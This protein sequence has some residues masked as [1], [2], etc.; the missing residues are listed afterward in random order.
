MLSLD[1]PVQAIKRAVGLNRPDNAI[2]M[3][4]MLFAAVIMPA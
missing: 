1:P 2:S 3:I 4:L